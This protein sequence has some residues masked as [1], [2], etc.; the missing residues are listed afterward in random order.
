MKKYQRVFRELLIIF[1]LFAFIPFSLPQKVKAATWWDSVAVTMSNPQKNAAGELETT[2]SMSQAPPTGAGLSFRLFKLLPNLG[3]SVMG[4]AQIENAPIPTA[5][6][7]YDCVSPA[8]DVFSVANVGSEIKMFRVDS[9]S[10]TQLK[11]TERTPIT[12]IRV[13]QIELFASGLCSNGRVK[14]FNTLASPPLAVYNADTTATGKQNY[15]DII[16]LVYPVWRDFIVQDCSQDPKINAFLFPTKPDCYG[17]LANGE[18]NL[19]WTVDSSLA[20][21]IKKTEAE[22]INTFTAGLFG[23]PD[24]V[25]KTF[26][27]TNEGESRYNFIVN[28][29]QIL[30]D[31]VT[32]LD[33]LGVTDVD[34]QDAHV[35][36]RYWEKEDNDKFMSWDK[37]LTDPQ[38]GLKTKIMAMADLFNQATSDLG[39]EGVAGVCMDKITGKEINIIAYIA[40]LIDEVSTGILNLAI[41][42]MQAFAGI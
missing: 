22:I 23:N 6:V 2:I 10:A 32:A 41:E 26:Y 7:T 28:T 35:T 12:G 38:V 25:S 15:L 1:V 3:R 40:C 34:V 5:A 14:Y 30:T 9:I 39:N 4:S 29:F 11:L 36:K 8:D 42:W 21:A 13:Y 37:P 33:S 27:L 31:C 17:T 24:S 18:T 19:F 20:A 16:D